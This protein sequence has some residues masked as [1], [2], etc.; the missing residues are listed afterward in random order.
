MN[1]WTRRDFTK[2]L[3]LAGATTALG[4]ARAAGAIGGKLTG[5]GGGGF[6]LLFVPREQQNKVRLALNKLL[7]VPFRFEFNGSQI[8]HYDPGED[9][10]AAEADRARET[11]GA[12]RELTQIQTTTPDSHRG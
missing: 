11:I 2:T 1:S 12:F 7:L 10:S 5:A 4:A 6:M 3:V 8:I 9:F